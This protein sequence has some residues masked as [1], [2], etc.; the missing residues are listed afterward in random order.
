M[1]L[2]KEFPK[3]LLKVPWGDESLG[4]DLSGSRQLPLS[5]G[6][7]LCPVS[8]GCQQLTF[9]FQFTRPRRSCHSRLFPLKSCDFF[10]AE[11]PFSSHFKFHS[12]LVGKLNVT[13]AEPFS[14]TYSTRV[15]FHP[16]FFC[17]IKGCGDV[18]ANMAD[19]KVLI[20]APL[21][22]IMHFL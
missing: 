14:L 4:C 12:I 10:P 2:T 16:L 22:D 8:S 17:S 19:D 7:V 6:R 9:C 3:H 15:V 11:L 21:W 20:K 1:E 5:W 18:R 13:H